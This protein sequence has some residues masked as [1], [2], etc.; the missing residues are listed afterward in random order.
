MARQYGDVFYTKIGGTD[1]VWLPSPKAVKNLMDKKSSMYSSRLPLPLA[2][3]VASAGRRQLFMQYGPRYRVVRR[4]SHALLSTTVATEYQPI[5]DL[6][7]KQLMAEILDE[8]DRFYD[9][10]RRHSSSVIIRIT[11][12]FRLQSWDHPLIKKI[13][14]VL[15]DVTVF[16][17]PGAHAVDSF[18]SL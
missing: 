3:D 14:S 1:Y 18:P 4:I 13:Y 15:N 16:T 7:S 17:A 5:R 8:P 9:Y 11:Y 10:N 6:E 12:G 2:Q